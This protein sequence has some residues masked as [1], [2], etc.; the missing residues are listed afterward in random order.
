MLPI[1]IT[2]LAV[3][4][5]LFAEQRGSLVGR[6]VAKPIASTGFLALALSSGAT[7]SRFGDAI[8]VA[9]ALSWLGDVLLIPRSMTWFRLGLGA[10]L[11]AHLAYATA[12][13]IRGVDAHATLAAAAALF[14]IGLPIAR[15]LL[16]HVQREM[17]V[18]VIA[19]MLLLSI[20]VA[21][22]VGTTVAEPQPLITVA[23]IA[24]YVS[25]LSVARDAFVAPSLSNK[26]W[27]LPLYYGAQ[28]LFAALAGAHCAR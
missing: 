23:A 3:A 27:G 6:S 1:L 17:K 28:L 9:L 20:M 19:Y 2:F 22:A 11:V 18:P 24:F 26:L 16:P 15:G 8:L 14:L 25:D 4:A 13:L 10:F 5:L 7:Q 21:L 12:F